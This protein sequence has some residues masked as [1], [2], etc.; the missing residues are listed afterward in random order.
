MKIKWTLDQPSAQYSARTGK[1]EASNEYHITADN[2]I[3]TCI[4]KG[5]K[6]YQGFG[7]TPSGAYLDAKES[8]KRG[9]ERK[10]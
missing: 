7:Q 8:E 6:K 3:C 10:S 4:L 9:E 5:K 2:R 1:D